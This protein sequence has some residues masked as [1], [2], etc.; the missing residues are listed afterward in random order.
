V[1]D[2]DQLLDLDRPAADQPVEQPGEAAPVLGDV[3]AAVVAE[4]DRGVAEVAAQPVAVGAGDV[5]VGLSTS[6]NS[7]NVVR[8]LETA[9]D[10][11]LVT[12][13]MTGAGGGK[14]SP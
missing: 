1:A 8:G 13:G 3:Q 5:A 4:E 9:R 10:C 12:V 14:L 2:E 11:G 6:G 7:P